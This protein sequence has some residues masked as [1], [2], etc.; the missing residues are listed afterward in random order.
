MVENVRLVEVIGRHAP[1]PVFDPNEPEPLVVPMIVT[2]PYH[3]LD[4]SE[5][6]CFS[7]HKAERWTLPGGKD[8]L[9]PPAV[10]RWALAW[11]P[12]DTPTSFAAI[13][14]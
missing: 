7:G 13:A 12:P 11:R 1:E 8:V 14:S 9:A 6:W 2:A 4:V 5:A 10:R 3:V